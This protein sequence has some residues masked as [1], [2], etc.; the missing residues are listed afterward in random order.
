MKNYLIE[1]VAALSHTLNVLT[2]GSRFYTFSARTYY[3]AQVLKLRRWACILLIIN[4][5]F[6]FHPNHCEREYNYEKRIGI[7]PV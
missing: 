7:T 1:I 3:C 4:A 5:I 6:F 2:L